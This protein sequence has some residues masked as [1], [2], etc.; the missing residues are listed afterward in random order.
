MEGVELMNGTHAIVLDDIPT[1][2]EKDT[3]KAIWKGRFVG[4]LPN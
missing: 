1:L 3:G 4:Y 2:L